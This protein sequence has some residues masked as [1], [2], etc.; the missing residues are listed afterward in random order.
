MVTGRDQVMISSG[1]IDLKIARFISVWGER[2]PNMTV[3]IE[4]FGGPRGWSADRLSDLGEQAAIYLVRDQEMDVH[5]EEF[6]YSLDARSE[7]PLCLM[8]RRFDAGSI[9][10]T[11]LEEPYGHGLGRFEPYDVTLVADGLYLITVVA[12]D[13]DSEFS[14]SVIEAMVDALS[15]R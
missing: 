11:A 9:A 1:P 3:E 15:G 4:G 13:E 6:G 8:Y 14:R 12:P 2:W 7:A 10:V 5:W